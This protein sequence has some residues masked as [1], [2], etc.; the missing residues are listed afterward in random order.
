MI[1]TYLSLKNK[2]SNYALLEINVGFLQSTNKLKEHS[3]ES[4]FKILKSE[5]G[6][7]VESERMERWIYTFKYGSRNHK[8]KKY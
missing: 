7:K 1:S 6:V 2:I 4:G 5:N 8:L 3:M